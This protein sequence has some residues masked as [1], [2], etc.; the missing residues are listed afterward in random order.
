[1]NDLRISYI[2]QLKGIAILL[3]VLGHVIGYNN[4]LRSFISSKKLVYYKWYIFTKHE[5]INIFTILINPHFS[6]IFSFHMPLFM[7]ISGYVA[8]MTFRIERF[9]WNETISFL[10]KKLKNFL[11]FRI[12]LL[13]F[14][15]LH[16]IDPKK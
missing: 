7:F 15:C 1:M 2:D 6:C 4:I 14:V 10:I 5:T 8:Q 3:V 11:L 16:T 13:K 12:R 9:G